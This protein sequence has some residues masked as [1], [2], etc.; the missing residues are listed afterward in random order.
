MT[1]TI[2]G[3]VTDVTARKDSRPWKVWSPVYRQGVNGEIITVTGQSV[4]VVGGVVTV[5]LEPGA[6][7]IENPDGQRYTVTIPD[8]DADLWDVIAA[9]VAF[10][11]N[12]AAE[13]LASA[14]TTYLE[15]NPSRIK[16]RVT[17][18]ASSATPSLAGDTYDHFNLT[19]QAVAITSVTMTGTPS[20]GEMKTVRIK[21]SGS[22]LAIAWGSAFTGTLLTTTIAG[23]THTQRLIWDAAAS[24]WAGIYAD[25][26]GY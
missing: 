13:A 22:P 8:E 10:P 18:V 1:V 21:D 26:S 2:T 14:V 7:V 12:T 25:T 9:A 20:D 19:S 23:K 6:A 17:A 15:D 5:E 4:K 16:P 3:K 24:K 11:P